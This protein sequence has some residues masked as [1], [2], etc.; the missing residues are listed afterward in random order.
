MCDF[1]KCA[2]FDNVF[3][4]KKKRKNS[5]FHAS[6]KNVRFKNIKTNL[7]FKNANQTARLRRIVISYIFIS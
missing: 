1:I 2:T 3:K 7:H 6:N 5:H 4:K